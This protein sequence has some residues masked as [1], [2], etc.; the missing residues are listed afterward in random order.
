MPKEIEELQNEIKGFKEAAEK[1]VAD[2]QKEFTEYK[3]ADTARTGEAEEKIDKMKADLASNLE[4]VT[5]IGTKL[6]ASE[7]A[8]KELE[9]IVSKQPVKGATEEEVKFM[10]GKPE[11]KEAFY[12]V[13]ESGGN[14]QL[15]GK[16]HTVEVYNELLEKFMPHI[17]G[18]KKDLALKAM[19]VGSDPDGGFLCPVDMSGRMVQRK[20]ETSPMRPE[21]TVVTTTKKAM[22]VLL[23]DTDITV[24]TA[25]EYDAATETTTPKFGELEI[26]THEIRA[27]TRISLQALED[28]DVNLETLLST[29]VGGKMGRKENQLFVTGTGAKEAKGFLSY[30]DWTGSSYTRNALLQREGE[31]TIA[32]GGL[33]AK[34]L[35]KLKTDLLEDYMRNAKFYMNR[36]VFTDITLL[37]DS[38]GQFL[39]NPRTLFE[40]DKLQLLGHKVVYMGDM[41][42]EQVSGAK[43]VAFGDM[44]ETY[45]ILDRLGVMMIPDMLTLPGWKKYFFR[46]RVGGGVVNFDSMKILVNK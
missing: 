27:Y 25:G 28:S 7:T 3:E 15:L 11:L 42:D 44:R 40:G 30:A 16:E 45:T 14:P 38:N 24:V 5:E 20:F 22:T 39:L 2:V 46:Y 4:K 18:D 31:Q 32:S 43:V 41:P 10:F 35:K 33:T 13:L 17:T 12:N 37:V 1:Q 36:N 23:D 8:R 29:K 21:A 26:E 34:D 19:S 6:E 9:L